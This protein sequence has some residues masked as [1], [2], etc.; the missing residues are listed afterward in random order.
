MKKVFLTGITGQLGS[1]LTE[2]YID[3]GYEVHGL[4]R[5]SSNTNT[6]RIDHIYGNKNL[7]LY[8]GDLSDYGSI[9]N[10]ISSL[11]PDIFINSGA[12][13]HVKVSFDV[14]EYTFDIDATG[15]IRCLECL[16]HFSPNTKFVQ[17]S[18]SEMFGGAPPPQN[19]NTPFKPK[20]PYACAKVAGY[21][22]TINYREAYG[23]NASNAICFNYESVNRGITF[24]TRKITLTAAK[25]KLGLES[26]LRLGN[27]DALRDWS[28]IED[29]ARAIMMIAE[30]KEPDDY[31]IGTGKMYSVKFFLEE[32][33][34]K[35]DLDVNKYVVIDPKYFRP[36]EVDALC[37]DY[38]KIKNKLGWEPKK[39]IYYLINEMVD[40]D[41]K[42][43]SSK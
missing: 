19:E 4:I 37:C 20:S 16:R 40:N 13:S 5:R 24:V 30:E 25:I 8:Y 26:E 33:F 10:I 28:H 17:L 36:T 34:K 2:K 11:K 32:V 43:L 1:F 3:L 23:L 38:S 21:F 7:K 6:N 39:D 18:T 41:L 31:T 29:T 15:V 9:V 12:M 42:L 27:L 35:L 22:S 14:P